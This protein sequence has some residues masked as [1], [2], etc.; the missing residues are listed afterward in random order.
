MLADQFPPVLGGVS[1]YV[2]NLSRSLIERGHSV[3][4]VT[5]G[6]WRK[7]QHEEIDGISVYRVQFIPSYPS[8]F[9]LHGIFVN[10]LFRR[11]EPRF[12]L[13]HVHGA[14]V[15]LIQTQLPTIFTSHGTVK[16][17][18]DNMPAESFHFRV[19]KMLSRQ[20]IKGERNLVQ[21]A[22]VI[23]AVSRSCAEDLAEYHGVNKEVTVVGNGVDSNF[24]APASEKE[25]VEP[26]ILYTGRLETRKG[27][28]TLIASAE[29]VCQHHRNLRFILVG[30]G[31]I[32]KMLKGMVSRLELNQ[33]FYFAGHV[34]DRIGLRR[35]YQNAT[36]Y[37]LPSYY[38]GLPTSLLEAMSC[39]IPSIATDVEGSSEVI[40]DG[41]TGLLVPPRDAR[42]LAEAIL[43]LLDDEDLQSRIGA[44]ARKHV[45]DNYDWPLVVDRIEAIYK[46]CLI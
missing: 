12:D 5:R 45:L 24:F 33:S 26:Y 42:L 34:T 44:N 4:V 37:V 40:T 17:D 16:K 7:S 9:W 11:L 19:V 22:D 27:L 35:Y 6:T 36:I 32:E 39:G 31:T 20:L 8:P 14:V 43:K 23:T 21:H 10:K 28:V 18:I 25:I 3:T 15:P 46:A 13:L 41:E 1:S 2:Y 29:H 30:R 38:E